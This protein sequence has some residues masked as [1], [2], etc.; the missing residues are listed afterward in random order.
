MGRDLSSGAGGLALCAAE[1][2]GAVLVAGYDELTVAEVEAVLGEG[3]E[4]RAKDVA[5]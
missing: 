3:D 5:A 1:H 4:Q 2:A